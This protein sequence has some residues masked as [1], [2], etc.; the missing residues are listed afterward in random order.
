[1]RLSQRRYWRFVQ[2]RSITSR[3]TYTF[4]F[5]VVLSFKASRYEDVYMSG[6]KIPDALNLGTVNMVCVCVCVCV[7][8]AS[9][10]SCFNTG[11]FRRGKEKKVPSPVGNWKLVRTQNYYSQAT[12]HTATNVGKLLE[13]RG[14]HV[15]RK[16]KLF[17]SCHITH[18]IASVT[19]Y[20]T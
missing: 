19:Q 4:K 7:C 12:L 20:D 10:T 9:C 8:S 13:N 17:S 11:M 16:S 18:A 1:L 5:S 6:C 3:K 14:A 2:G 15:S